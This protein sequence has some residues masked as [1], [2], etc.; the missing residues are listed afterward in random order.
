MEEGNARLLLLWKVQFVLSC[1]E[2]RSAVICM[3]GGI[4]TA[5]CA[6]RNVEKN[7]NS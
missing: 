1:E 5:A 2:E 6:A 3:A 4:M 7:N